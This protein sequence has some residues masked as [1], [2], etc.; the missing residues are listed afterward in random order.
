M[1]K[2]TKE[3]KA[4]EEA[5]EKVKKAETVKEKPKNEVKKVETV[6][7]KPKKD[8]WSKENIQYLKDNFQTT[9]WKDILEKLPYPKKEIEIKARE[10]KLY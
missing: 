6:K 10:L 9:I 2:K 4:M 1:A 3:T 5:I 8:A 7:E